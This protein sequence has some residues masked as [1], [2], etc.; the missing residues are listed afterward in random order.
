MLSHASID[1]KMMPKTPVSPAHTRLCTNREYL[2]AK[3][4][5]IPK[6]IINAK[7]SMNVS[8]EERSKI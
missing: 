1:M 2:V 8:G 7:G 5:D 6:K 3:R 4:K